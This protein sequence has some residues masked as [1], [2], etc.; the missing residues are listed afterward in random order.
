MVF[1]VFIKKPVR[2][3]KLPHSCLES[4][5]IMEK[6][7]HSYL[8]YSLIIGGSAIEKKKTIFINQ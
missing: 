4:S 6:K 1:G 2:P 7:S 3:F 5:R 8:N